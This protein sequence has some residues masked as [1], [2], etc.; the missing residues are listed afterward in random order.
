MRITIHKNDRFTSG[1]DYVAYTDDIIIDAAWGD[2]PEEVISKLFKHIK[3]KERLL[4]IK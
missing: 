2:T 3:E 1:Q 4:K